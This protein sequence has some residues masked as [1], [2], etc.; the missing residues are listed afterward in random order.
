M[1]TRKS[2]LGRKTRK[3]SATNAQTH[4][5][6]IGQ[7]IQVKTGDKQDPPIDRPR[8]SP[9]LFI[10]GTTT[11][12]AS[13]LPIWEASSIL[14]R[15]KDLPWL[16]DPNGK[17]CYAR[18]VENG[19]GAIHFWVTEDL[20]HESPAILAGAAALAVINAFDIRAAC[21][22]LIYAAHS[23]QLDKPWEQEFVIDDRQIEEYLGLKKRTDINKQQKLALIE[24]IAQ[25]AFKITTYISWPAQGK[26]K[27]FTVEE[28][29]L[30]HLLGTRYHYQQ[31]LLGNEELIGIT[32]VVRAGLW[33][34]Y[35]LNEDRRADLNTHCQY[36]ILSKALLEDVMSV[37]QHR[38]GAARL[39]VW[40][41][42]KTRV[43][44]K[45]SL[46]VQSLMEIA[47]GTQ[48][49]EA[50]RQNSQLRKKLAN[51]WDED[52][53]TIH[54]RGWHLCFHPET[55]PKEIQPAGFGRGNHSRPRG[56]FEQL[57]SARIWINPPE[58][59]S[60]S[61]MTLKGNSQ[62]EKRQPVLQ[63]ETQRILSGAEVRTLRKE[64]GWSQRKLELATGI[65]QGLICQIENERRPISRENQEILGRT[66][67]MD[68]TT[69]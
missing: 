43:D 24:E 31:D 47:Y 14:T 19:K 59:L 61:A 66:F 46:I 16:D 29:R 22:H 65:S 39:L 51:T 6:P 69:D 48:R 18:D 15:R 55:Y 35:F 12:M 2:K 58:E 64:K 17:L 8:T 38:E 42:F 32:F 3:Q 41:L 30:W 26:V 28:G 63:F 25:Q 49:I 52:L 27:G 57:L 10:D 33:A 53:L 11:R 56:F 45:Q 21:M 23:T 1:M 9:A 34:K 44:K 50:A 67:A 40:L 13:A 5:L 4:K 60:L 36:G 62:S 7:L 68:S 37:W 20:E 54:D